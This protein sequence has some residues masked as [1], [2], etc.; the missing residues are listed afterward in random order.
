MSCDKYRSIQLLVFFNSE[1]LLECF[2]ISFS[3]GD[4]YQTVHGFNSREQDNHHAFHLWLQFSCYRSNMLHLWRVGMPASRR[5]LDI[6][7][8]FSWSPD[9]RDQFSW[10][11]KWLLC[12]V[13]P[14]EL[15]PGEIFP[16]PKPCPLW[17]PFAYLQEFSYLELAILFAIE[18]H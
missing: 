7:W 6:T 9:D 4:R 15:Y 2:K 8:N 1:G 5:G 17:D 11:K 3:W 10:R 14:M 12:R 13:A 18:Y 16:L